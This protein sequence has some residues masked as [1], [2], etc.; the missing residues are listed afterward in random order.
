MKGIYG[1]GH[2]EWS[3]EL[4]CGRGSLLR[5]LLDRLGD[6]ICV[7]A[8]VRTSRDERSYDPEAVTVVSP[9][10]LPTDFGWDCRRTVRS[11]RLARLAAE[12][13]ANIC[14]DLHPFP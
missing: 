5:K 12:K 8:R 14:T 13:G 1:W 2:A 11:D 6:D 4:T 10:L 9:T 3:E 7:Y